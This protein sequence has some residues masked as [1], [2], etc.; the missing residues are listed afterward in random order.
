[1]AR[2]RFVASQR[3]PGGVMSIATRCLLLLSLTAV[4]LSASAELGEIN[5]A[6]QYGVSF[7]PLMLMERDKLVEKHAKAEGLGDI[8]VSWVKVAGPSVMNDGVISGALQF[9]AVGAPS[10]ITLW[11]RT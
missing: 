9:I 11:D 5:V 4:A 1:M 3:G 2:R 10:L 8:K 6:Q 7:L